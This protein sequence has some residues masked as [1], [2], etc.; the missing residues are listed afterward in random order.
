MD[1]PE[2]IVDL[3]LI[4][5][6]AAVMTL[7]FKWL[8][9]PIVL[10]Y[11]IAG[12]LVGP[13]FHFLPTIHDE[14]NIHTWSQIGVIFMLFGLG[15]EFSFRKLTHVGKTAAITATFEIICMIVAGY[16][17]GRII[18][19]DTMSSLFLGAILSMS[20]T[21]II[22]KAFSE[23]NLKG[24]N[25]ASV[26]FGV[27]IVEDLIA[28]LLLVLLGSIAV[29]QHLS[30]TALI[31]SSLK[32]VFFLILWFLLGIYL[33]PVFFR[34]CR[35]VLTDEILLI[36]AMALCFMMVI[37]AV[38]VGF[39]AALG[40]FVMGSLL[41]ETV[42]GSKIEE[43]IVPVKDLFS[44]IFFVSVG[45]L[46]DPKILVE[47]FNIIILLT[48]ITIVGKFFGTAIGALISGCN[49]KS[50][51]QSGMSMA[52][53]GEFSFIIASL[54]MTL[55][56]TDARLYP[57][58]V[59]VSAITTFTTPYLIKYSGVIADS[60]E[61]RIPERVKQSLLRYELTMRDTGK[62]G[63]VGLIWKVHGIK[64]L[65]NSVIIVAITLACRYAAAPFI[66]A[67]IVGENFVQTQTTILNYIMWLAAVILSAPF[68][69]AIFISRPPRSGDYD[70]ETV[71]LL[72]RLYFGVSIV[73][74]F[75]GFA[76]VA[77]IFSNFLPIYASSGLILIPFV[78]LALVLFSNYFEPVYHKIETQFITHLTEKEK[79]EIASKA[80]LSN[81]APWNV[82]LTEF[83]LSQNSSLVAK[84][85]KEAKLRNRFGVIVAMI[86]RGNVRFIPPKGEDLLLPFDKI[87][88]LG[89]DAQLAAARNEIEKDQAN[90]PEVTEVEEIGL[91]PVLLDAEHPFVGLMVLECGI[92]ELAG[93]LIVGIERGVRRQL[94]PMP[95]M[96]LEAN[97][98]LWIVGNK[99]SIKQLQNKRFEFTSATNIYQNTMVDYSGY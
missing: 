96:V 68:V 84:S 56:V 90:E 14:E 40:A 15:L 59:A 87:F 57:I 62:R 35:K 89:T 19:W 48:A 29:T 52:Q 3:G 37:V 58:A 30:G 54:G 80:K 24:I 63:I 91:M 53:I 77:F 7:L 43:L 42:K 39:S 83:R 26:V 93:G 74:L 8:K 1:L 55:K 22:V 41:A 2:L 4:L 97:D 71:A 5:M 61:R 45:L 94:N 33:L 73:R 9:Q 27:L 16:V 17:I 32:L 46:I 47:Y 13:H 23:Q 6:A 72:Q 10:G 49:V 25:F 66:A 18:G 81:L 64:I 92:R 65:L 44:A 34:I 12:F 85:L 67:P 60:L 99:D 86:E 78:V 82:T 79:E 50:S 28:I 38:K 70:T 20:S 11:L 98:L 75:I 36:V 31:S 69:W 88:M 51:M 76:L 21:T 95:E